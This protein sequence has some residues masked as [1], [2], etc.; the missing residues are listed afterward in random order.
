MHHDSKELY[1]AMVQRC[2]ELH[3]A[4]NELTKRQME[5]VCPVLGESEG[6]RIR[7]GLVSYLRADMEHNPSQR[8]IFYDEA[9]AFLERWKD[10]FVLYDWNEYKDKPVELWNSY[11]HGLAVG[12]ERGKVAVMNNPKEYG[13]EKQ[14]DQK[15]DPFGDTLSDRIPD[16]WRMNLSTCNPSDFHLK[17]ENMDSIDSC[18]LRYLQSA[19]NKK[20][21]DE[22]MEDTRKY[23]Q[24]LV[25][26]IQTPAGWCE[27]DENRRQRCV[28]ILNQLGTAPTCVAWLKSLRPKPLWKPDDSNS[29]IT[30][31]KYHNPSYY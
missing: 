19:A 20:D 29:S 21:D 15:P 8:R 18:M 7:K 3:E 10:L 28:E 22:I 26:L 6:E 13:L 23:K 2:R 16:N 31:G 9:I 14:K 5:I 17:A 27:E 24:E 4:G 30:D 12:L 1:E 11:I 25:G